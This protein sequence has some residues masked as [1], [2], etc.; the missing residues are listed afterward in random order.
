LRRLQVYRL[1]GLPPAGAR[2]GRRGALRVSS[3]FGRALSAPISA[4]V[5]PEPPPGRFPA[6]TT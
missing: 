3:R 1:S 4:S 2:D 6:A 5:W